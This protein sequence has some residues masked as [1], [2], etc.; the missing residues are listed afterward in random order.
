MNSDGSTLQQR[1]NPS[2]STCYDYNDNSINASL[3]EE[4]DEENWHVGVL[5]A[6]MFAIVLLLV[7]VVLFALGSIYSVKLLI[8]AGIVSG[9]MV[10]VIVASCYDF[11]CCRCLTVSSVF[12]YRSQVASNTNTSKRIRNDN[13][14]RDFS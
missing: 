3:P 7:I 5:F 9:V 11:R 1:L 13:L 2:N 8:L 12:R 14:V 6:R 10:L 4:V